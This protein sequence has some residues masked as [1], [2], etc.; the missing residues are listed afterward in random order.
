MWGVL[1]YSFLDGGGRGRLPWANAIEAQ[2]HP[3]SGN[4]ALGFCHQFEHVRS[5]LGAMAGMGA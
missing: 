2:V 5:S 3:L 4:P 1:A